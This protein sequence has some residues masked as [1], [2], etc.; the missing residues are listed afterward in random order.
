LEQE[1]QE[2]RKREQRDG[3]GYH[4]LDDKALYGTD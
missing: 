2:L 4:Y 1:R 3:E